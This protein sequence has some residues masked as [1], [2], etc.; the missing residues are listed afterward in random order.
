[1]RY[2]IWN[3]KGGVGKTFLC[4]M[5]ASE[6]ARLNP[7]TP[8]VVFDM[9]PQ[10]NI[11]EILLGGN[12]IGNTNLDVILTKDDRKTIGGY[13]DK[14]L[15]KPDDGNIGI[16]SNYKFKVKDYAPEL[17]ENLWLV[18]GDPSLEL[19][20][21]SINQAS[22]QDLPDARWKN[23]HL[24]LFDLQQAFRA[25]FNCDVMFFL[26]CNPSFAT[27][28]AQALIASD[29]VIVPCTADGSSAR[30]ID[31]LAQLLYA[32][33]I[34]AIYKKANFYQKAK[35]FGLELPKIHSIILNRSTVNR[36]KPASAFAAMYNKIKER[37]NYLK[38]S[39]P[40]EFTFGV[41]TFVDM[42]DAHTVSIVASHN[43]ITLDKIRAINY[44]IG[45][46]KTKINKAPLER[47]NKALSK[48]VNSL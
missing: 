41:E 31:N 17:P 37:V 3:N 2:S 25:D 29:R 12:G 45:G 43:A 20:V 10:A 18:P 36:D 13:F 38:N 33:K 19:Q 7:N 8:V 14:R 21:Q 44:E 32:E 24:W 42:P 22:A 11:S 27:Y 39:R 9:C 48:I 46:K 34:P 4:F 47:Y 30:A 1:M 5:L 40:N 6:Y 16:E 23:V 26:D 28:T 35:D 15:S